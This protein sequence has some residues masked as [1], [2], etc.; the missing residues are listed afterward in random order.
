MTIDYCIKTK[1]ISTILSA[2]ILELQVLQHEHK[3]TAF[4]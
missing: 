4:T 2:S 3:K 1:P